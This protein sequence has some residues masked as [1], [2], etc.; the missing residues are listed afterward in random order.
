[1]NDNAF[2]NDGPDDT[3]V[4]RAVKM[5]PV[6]PA[7]IEAAL[8]VHHLLRALSFGDVDGQCRF[9]NASAMRA[10]QPRG[11]SVLQERCDAA[12]SPIGSGAACRVPPRPRTA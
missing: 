10:S 9:L 3:V 5:P 2:F 1:M 7:C 4:G 8:N 12:K 6:S 11:H